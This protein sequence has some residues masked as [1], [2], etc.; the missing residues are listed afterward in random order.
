MIAS[1][2]GV[3]FACLCIAGCG[4]GC[5]GSGEPLDD[6][7]PAEVTGGETSGGREAEPEEIVDP[8]PAPTLRVVGEPDPHS[9]AVAIRIE[10][11][12]ET[13]TELAGAV[14]L[15]RQ[16]GETFAD[17]ESVH[18]DLRY[19]CEDEAAECVTL[20]PGATY[21]PPEWLG[22]VGDAQCI[23]TRCA[24]AEPGTYR[25]VVRSCNGAHTVAGEPFEIH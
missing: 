16:S 6:D 11:R 21:L 8:G 20:A 1:R 22:T 5:G 12:G 14:G 7:P 3:A 2:F 25:F 23:C 17:V 24:P 10:N 13:A 18:L 19:S 15:Q 9:R 4:G